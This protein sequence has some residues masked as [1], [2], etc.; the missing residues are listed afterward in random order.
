MDDNEILV[1]E[2]VELAKKN[3]VKFEKGTPKFRRKGEEGSFHIVMVTSRPNTKVDIILDANFSNLQ[4]HSVKS[5][6]DYLIEEFN[7]HSA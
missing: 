3:G 5:I 1:R 4:D 7:K 2:A 6:A